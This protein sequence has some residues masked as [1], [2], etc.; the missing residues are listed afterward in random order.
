MIEN[1][2][3]CYSTN[4]TYVVVKRKG[5]GSKTKKK[6]FDKLCLRR[7]EEGAFCLMPSLLSGNPRLQKNSLQIARELQ[8]AKVHQ[9]VQYERRRCRDVRSIVVTDDVLLS[10]RIV[11]EGGIVMR[12]SQLRQLI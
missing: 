11:K 5:G 10:D 6:L 4:E 8:R 2:V 3:D 7:A 1:A 12:Y 9:V